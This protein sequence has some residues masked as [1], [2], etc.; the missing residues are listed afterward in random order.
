MITNAR[1]YFQPA[2]LNNVGEPTI[3]FSLRNISRMY[4]RRHL[5]RQIGLELFMQD[6]TSVLFSFETSAM[7]SHVYSILKS[8]PDLAHLSNTS[9]EDVTRKWQEGKVSN[10]EYLMYLNN[11]ADR[12]VN[13]LAQYP[14]FPWVI[15]V[16]QLRGNT[17]Y[18]ILSTV[19]D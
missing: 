6:G 3:S 16:S 2:D 1:I 11:E 9:I 18:S 7:Q 15:K 10:F 13:D 19:T 5:L 12:S 8:H 17:V 14:V 4:K